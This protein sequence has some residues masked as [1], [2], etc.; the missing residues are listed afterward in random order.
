MSFLD[1]IIPREIRE[2]VDKVIPNELKPYVKTLAATAVPAYFN[3]PGGFMSDFLAGAGGD[4]FLDKLLYDEDADKDTDYLSA[5][6]SGI[7]GALAG[8][9]PQT[10]RRVDLEKAGIEVNPNVGKTPLSQADY[11]ASMRDQGFTNVSPSDYQKYAAGFDGPEFRGITGADTNVKLL[12]RLNI[13]D[14]N[15][16]LRALPEN[17]TNQSGFMNVLKSDVAQGLDA[18]ATPFDF[19]DIGASENPFMDVGKE[20]LSTASLAQLGQTPSQVR[21]AAKALEAAERQYEN[22]LNTLDAE[23]RASI[24]DDINARIAAYKQYMGLA[25]YTNAEIDDALMNAGYLAS[26]ETAYAARGGRIGFDIGGDTGGMTD[27]MGL[28]NYMEAEKVRTEFM[29][30]MKRG[31]QAAEMNMKL[32]DPGLMRF[33]N[34]IVPGGEDFYTRE[35]MRFP[36]MKERYEANIEKMKRDQARDDFE[37]RQLQKQLRK[38]NFDMMVDMVDDRFSENRQQRKMANKGGR[39]T[40]QGDPISPDVPNGMQ[41]DLRG[42]GFIPLG[43]KPKADDVPA[44][45]GLNEFVLNDEAVSGIGKLITG[46]PD[47][48][49]GA[50][51]LYQLQDQMEAIV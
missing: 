32:D 13:Q 31:L 48:R 47:P 40:P 51:A 6:M 18:F 2:G 3:I 26:G 44:M 7:L 16:P 20:V 27:R 17:A 9:D 21:D 30:K 42:G 15:D 35:E 23:N 4:I 28:G 33:V 36:S 14:V 41:M 39:M 12:D 46:K 43:T 8:M 38:E 22:Y 5:T 11:V 45:V 10:K 29:D 34:A 1:D 24:Q 25:G 49:A 37:K 50:R 19:R